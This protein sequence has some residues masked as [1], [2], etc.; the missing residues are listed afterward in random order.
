MFFPGYFSFRRCE[1]TSWNGS[2]FI[3]AFLKVARNH[4][5][6]HL[7]EILTAVNYELANNSDYEKAGQKCQLSMYEAA[8]SKIFY[9]WYTHIHA[10]L[11][12]WFIVL[13]TF[14]LHVLWKV[15][16]P[17]STYHHISNYF[18]DRAM[19]QIVIRFKRKYWN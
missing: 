15:F 2:W 4:P 11:K 16:M 10:I 1:S 17:F 13:H 5:K 19:K 6:N 18:P 14:T 12:K 3:Q 8:L 9:F 7:L